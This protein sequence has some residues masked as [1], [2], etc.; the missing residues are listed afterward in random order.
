MISHSKADL[1]DLIWLKTFFLTVRVTISGLE[2]KIK[3]FCVVAFGG[4]YSQERVWTRKCR[5]CSRVST[6][7]CRTLG[8]DKGL[9]RWYQ[10]N[11]AALSGLSV[12]NE[13]GAAARIK[14]RAAHFAPIRLRS[15]DSTSCNIKLAT[16]LQTTHHNLKSDVE[17]LI[18]STM[19]LKQSRTSNWCRVS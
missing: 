5:V 18:K 7:L 14:L 19:K 10:Q 9:N 6:L 11:A 12:C 13:D 3:T 1:W 17:F 8:E 15:L 16:R 2:K 4:N